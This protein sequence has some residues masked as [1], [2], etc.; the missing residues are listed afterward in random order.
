[1]TTDQ[2]EKNDA[3]DV[4]LVRYGQALSY[5]QYENSTYWQRFSF[6]L[7][8][9]ALLISG[10]AQ[11]CM[12]ALKPDS[13]FSMFIAFGAG[14]LGLALCGLGDRMAK[15]SACWIDHWLKI[16]RDLEPQAYPG[17]RLFGKTGDEVRGSHRPS[18][19]DTANHVMYLFIVAWVVLLA[20]LAGCLARC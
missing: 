6:I 11:Q 9:Q 1:M 18:V 8:V 13:H 3:R 16:L 5:L 20:L 4:A 7:A 14:V 10:A 12:E 19:R 2:P 17:T 15:G